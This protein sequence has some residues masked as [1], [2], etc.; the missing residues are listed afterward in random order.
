MSSQWA[1]SFMWTKYC[2]STK[3]LSF[4]WTTYC[5]FSLDMVIHGHH[6]LWIH[7]RHGYLCG[8]KIVK[9]LNMWSCLWTKILWNHSKHSQDMVIYVDYIVLKSHKTVSFMCI[10]YCDFTVHT[11]ILW[12]HTIYCHLITYIKYWEF[13]QDMLL[14]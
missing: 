10:K 6:I 9:S 12:I 5:E 11:N 13:M 2:E 1:L 3:I 8:L 4:M 7:S 14:M